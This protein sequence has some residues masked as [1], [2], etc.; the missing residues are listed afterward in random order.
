MLSSRHYPA[1]TATGRYLGHPPTASRIALLNPSLNL[2][3]YK[4]GLVAKPLLKITD[5]L[6][7]F[8]GRSRFT[9]WAQK[10]TINSAFTELRRRRWQDLSLQEMI[11]DQEGN[12]YTPAILTD[13]E[14][15]PEDQ[16]TRRNF[17]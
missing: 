2:L 8:E 7:S 3:R 17:A 11:E 6:D 5:S 4:H 12:E 15:T 10:I 13:P 14:A 9:T 16:T 1:R